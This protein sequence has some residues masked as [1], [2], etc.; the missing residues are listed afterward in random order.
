MNHTWSGVVV[1][2]LTV[3]AAASDPPNPKASSAER[4]AAIMKEHKDAEAAFHKAVK[5]VPDSPDGQK[6]YEGLWSVF[7][8]GQANRFKD[9]VDLARS[10]PKSD[11]GFAAL[12]WVLTIPRSYYL[13]AGKPALELLT[14][15][16]AAN[17]K[18][19]KI[20]AWVGFYRP[21]GVESSP[22]AFVLIKRVAEKNPDRTA[23]GQAVMAQAW[24]AGRNFA[25]AE[26]KK[27]PAM[28]ELAAEAE[29]A[30]E[31]VVMDYYDCPLLMRDGMRPLG[32]EAQQELYE[33]RNLR[34][35]KVAPDIQGEDL[36]GVK[37]KLSD[38]RG[39]VTMVVF[40]ATWCGPC[41]A[42]VPHE[43]KLVA[44]LK[45]KPFVLVGV[46]GDEDRAKAKQATLKQEMT[47]HSFWNGPDRTISRAW[48]VRAWPMIYVL[49]H[50]G[51]IRAKGIRSDEIDQVV[52]HLLAE[53]AA[54]K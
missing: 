51:M 31:A 8:K 38:F 43:R 19:G 26:Y 49:N 11:V 3:A 53:L 37:F 40:W 25:V 46:N 21:H 23:R 45:D 5:P 1:L 54:E 30:F 7:D 32:E 36:D 4:L 16:H 33:L 22:A 18:V 17:P 13:P 50:K 39:K 48:N 41:M 14:E 20:V 10:D 47:W 29:K 28:D 34:V 6:N 42:M 35:G 24:Q 9:A 52:D 44:R 15:H 12:E 2:F 27:A